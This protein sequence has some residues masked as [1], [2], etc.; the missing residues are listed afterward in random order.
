[1]FLQKF[2]QS[3]FASAEIE[4][5]KHAMPAECSIIF[6]MKSDWWLYSGV[7][8]WFTTD[9]FSTRPQEGLDSEVPATVLFPFVCDCFFNPCREFAFGK[10][11]LPG[12]QSFQYFIYLIGLHQFLPQ[13]V[14]DCCDDVINLEITATLTLPDEMDLIFSFT[15]TALSAL[16]RSV[17]LFT[18]CCGV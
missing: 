12:R 9:C 17:I 5:L 6:K 11:L 18:H 13:G 3:L 2:F 1:M 16:C 8:A 7:M 4:T 14:F 10:C 15:A